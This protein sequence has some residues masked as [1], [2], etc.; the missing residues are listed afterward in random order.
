MIEEALDGVPGGATP[1][2]DAPPPSTRAR[3]LRG[4]AELAALAAIV[5]LALF[6]RFAGI[7]WGTGY[8]LHPDELF[9]SIVVDRI[10]GPESF[11][12]YLDSA[13]SPLNPFNH[14]TGYVYGTFPLFAAELLGSFTDYTSVNTNHIPGRWLSAIAD[15]GTVVLVWWIGRMLF[16]RLTGL[17]A[18]LLLAC[19]MLHIQAAHYFTTDAWS[20]FFATAT[21]AFVLAGWQ[22]RRWSMYALAG[23]ALGLAVASKPN[24]LA[25]IGFVALPALETIRVHGWGALRP[26]WSRLS[27]EDESSRNFPVLLASALSVFVAIW[28]FRLLQP[29]AFQGPSLFSFRFDQRWLDDIEYW[30]LVQSGDLDYYPGIQ[31]VE[32]APVVFV[33]ENLVKW[34]MGPGLGLTAL[35]GTGLLTWKIIARRTWPSWMI[36]GMVGWIAFH[37]LYFGSGVVKT[38]RYLLPAYPLMTVVAAMTLV[39]LAR[40]AHRRGALRLPRLGWSM[41]FPQWIHPGYVLPVLVVA[42][43]ILYGV[44]F[45]SIYTQP[46]TRAE[47]S[48]WIARN[49]PDGSVLG[50]EYWDLGLPV[51]VPEVQGKTYTGIDL[52]LYGDEVPEKVPELVAALDQVD[53]VILSSNRLI[54]SITRMPERY[55]MATRYYEALY[56]GVLGFEQVAHFTS[57]PEL[58]GIE[59]DDRGAEETLTV[60]D[61]PEVTIF[62]K[63]ESWDPVAATALLTEALG[64]GGLNIRPVQ[65][66]PNRMMLDG[67][68]QVELA[69]H[70]AWTE[71][72][73]PGSWA[74]KLPVLTW[75]L[76]LQL[77]SLPAIPFLWRFAPWLP[78][79]GYA[80]ARTIG[81]FAV[82]W[83]VW[84]LCGWGRLEFGR[85][86]IVVAWLALTAGAGALLW[87]RREDLVQEVRTR[88]P[89][90]VATEAILAA[91][92]LL[93]TWVRA[94]NPDLW[95]PG[96]V[97]TQLQN[98]A[99]F[100]A[101]V[102]TPHFPAYDPW[103]ADGTIHD[104]IF[105]LMPWTVM[106]RLTGIMPETAFSLALATLATLALLNAW[107][108]A[109][110]L[111]SRVRPN[112]RAWKSIAAALVAPI[113]LLLIGSWGMAQ[114]VGAGNWSPNFEGSPID[115]VAGFWKTII[116]NPVTPP[117][118]WYST[119]TFVGPGVLEFPLLSYLTGELA[120]QQAAMPLVLAAL[121]LLAGYLTCPA[122]ATPEI[123]GLLGGWRRG[124]GFLLGFGLVAGWTLATNLLA[125]GA[126]VGLAGFLVLLAMLTCEQLSS[127][128][129][130]VR[131]AV[132]AMAVLGAVTVASVWPFLYHYGY[133]PTKAIPLEQGI[134]IGEYVGH[135]G[136]VFVVAVGY[137]LWQVVALGRSLWREGVAS[138]L[139]L[140][141]LTVLMTA[142]FG[143][144]WL[145]GHLLTFLMVLFVLAGVVTWRHHRDPG[146]VLVPGILIAAIGLGVVGNRLRLEDWTDQQ[147]V[148]LQ[149]S[150]ITWLLLGVI[151]APIIALGFEA[152]WRRATPVG[153]AARRSLSIAWTLVLAVALGAGAVYTVLALPDR[154]DAR[155]AQT[156]ATLDAWAF[157]EAGQLGTN[158]SGMAVSPYPLADDLDA[159]TWLR[160]NVPGLPVILEAP[161]DPGTWAGRVSALT[162]Y[163]SLLGS[164]AVEFQ[165]RPGMDRLV[166]WRLEDINRVYGEV[167]AF[168]VIAPLLHEYGVTYIYVGALERATYPAEALAKFDTAAAA[169]SLEVVYQAGEVTIYRVLPAVG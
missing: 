161:G 117:E 7:K 124:L 115:A 129:P 37:V 80:L 154:A 68:Q 39:A 158:A 70:G 2:P 76:A 18:A 51:G 98:M 153:M 107:S 91:G 134:G 67:Q 1:D 116:G 95:I 43:T 110:V 105:G 71:I 78:D 112:G 141:G 131:D 87:R 49:I 44:A 59:V 40:W 29:Y 83:V 81:P 109:A 33:V 166:N 167:S 60:Y 65:T 121:A 118:A 137:L 38:Q 160:E 120:V 97:G 61:H 14:E 144:A 168:E 147:N 50:T 111:V 99:T 31:W 122:P 52:H 100:N 145:V 63:T 27:D 36:L 84:W 133:I 138:P 72:A 150:V 132:V 169:G 86:V 114:R 127:S 5:A 146:Q 20:A 106:T 53:F 6:L 58:F 4:L 30:R 96:R 85:P 13:T 151:A 9:M 12:A 104:V 79:R 139:E 155:L 92:F 90:L 108:V 162:G 8:Y 102:R 73:D 143:L 163:P 62:R 135:L 148:P 24:L 82:A 34:G 26:R 57:Y 103:L 23:F 45:V 42:S 64:Q 101:L 159:I 22:K 19:T 74:N 93:A 140:A 157:M 149:F 125:G 28:T 11:R 89:W 119:D 41:R 56:S 156:D 15:T 113:M 88:L 77:M 10:S 136:A 55:P 47:A 165:Q 25:A 66:Q 46:Q 48:V 35:A 152:G 16:G 164:P 3:W 32:R 130:L 142:T 75:Y 54:D 21:F 94:Q 126:L 17:L 69:T 128:W 123:L